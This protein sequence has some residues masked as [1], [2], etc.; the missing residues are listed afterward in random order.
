MY[1]A[2][3]HTAQSGLL[4][5]PH[6]E[7]ALSASWLLMPLYYWKANGK[8]LGSANPANQHQAPLFFLSTGPPLQQQE[9]SK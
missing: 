3:G 9:K 5:E 4:W 8:Q 1:E 6:Q 7:V 2:R